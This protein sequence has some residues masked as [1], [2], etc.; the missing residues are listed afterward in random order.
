MSV[1]FGI[2][3][4]LQGHARRGKSG[5]IYFRNFFCLGNQSSKGEPR[6]RL[7]EVGVSEKRLRKYGIREAEGE[8]WAWDRASRAARKAF[9]ISHQRQPQDCTACL[10]ACQCCGDVRLM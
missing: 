4:D 9:C 10:R 2:A 3:Q 6:T 5:T 8:E 1:E 7:V